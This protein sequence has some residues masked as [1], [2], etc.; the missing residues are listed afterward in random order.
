ME[1]AVRCVPLLLFTPCWSLNQLQWHA[2]IT[3]VPASPPSNPS[4][5]PTSAP[6]SIPGLNQQTP[7]GTHQKPLPSS[8][9]ASS[10]PPSTRPGLSQHAHAGTVQ[11]PGAGLR[12]PAAIFAGKVVES[13]PRSRIAASHME[14]QQQPPQ[15]IQHIKHVNGTRCCA[16]CTQAAQLPC[17]SSCCCSIWVVSINWQFEG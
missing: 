13:L 5:I 8:F 7:A 17:I 10:N 2:G 1:S 4:P 16:C 14:Q 11:K 3:P 15:V 9:L 12:Q 6:S